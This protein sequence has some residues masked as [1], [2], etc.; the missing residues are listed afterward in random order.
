MS[1]I[2][3]KIDKYNSL[4]IEAAK[5]YRLN[6]KYDWFHGGNPPANRSKKSKKK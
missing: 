3:N 2:L 4:M 6:N 1:N 5:S